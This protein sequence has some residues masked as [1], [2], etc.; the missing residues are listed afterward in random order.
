MRLPLWWLVLLGLW[1]L[2]V[3]TSSWLQL[4]GGACGA[5]AAAALVAAVRRR[6]ERRID[7]P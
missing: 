2:L 5:T 3:G 6:S 1:L 7:V 4:V